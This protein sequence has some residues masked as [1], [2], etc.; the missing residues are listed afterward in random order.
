MK[1]MQVERTSTSALTFA[2]LLGEGPMARVALAAALET[3]G[4][5][6]FIVSQR[7]TV[8]HANGRGKRRLTSD[9]ERTK[10]E[11]RHAATGRGHSSSGEAPFVV[12][13]RCEGKPPYFLVVFRAAPTVEKNVE[14]AASLWDLTPKQTEVL[15]LVVAGFSNKTIASRLR[16]A[17]RTVESHLT[18]I[19][20][21]SGIG[22]RTALVAMVVRSAL[23][24]NGMP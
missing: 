3:V 7:G 17:E 19:F 12:P 1:V 21:K 22:G 6:A 9:G 2:R 8:L 23:G 4:G 24:A 18:A 11:L 16:C 13:L 15:A 5:D 20:D 14:Y 10:L